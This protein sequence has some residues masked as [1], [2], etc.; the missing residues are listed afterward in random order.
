MISVAIDGPAGAG[1]STLSR[2][3]AE[4][5][6]YI[7]VDT[8]AMYRAVGLKLIRNGVDCSDESVVSKLLETTKVEIA[9]E[10]G[11]QIVILD[12][13][14]VNG[15]IRTPEVSM[16]ASKCSALPTVRAFLLNM[17]RNLAKENSVVMDGRDIGTVVLPNAQVKIFLTASVEARSKRRYD[18]LILKGED[19]TLE[20]VT[21]DVIKRDYN[22]THREIAPLKPSETSVIV[23]T[24]EINFEQSL[25]LLKQTVK[26]VLEG[27]K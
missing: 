1:K 14:N 23:D 15:L 2:K 8:G 26:N 13:E 7:Y 17:Q 19:V 9:Y 11:S 5:L 4:S 21:A 12:G 10:D 18:E 16:M 22:D 6:G 27:A 25:E 3:L 24:T 20:D